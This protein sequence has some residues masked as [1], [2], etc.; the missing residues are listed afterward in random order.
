MSAEPWASQ[1]GEDWRDDPEVFDPD[2]SPDWAERAR[3]AAL[4][5]EEQEE[6]SVPVR[7][8]AGEVWAAG[9]V[10]RLPGPR[11]LGFAAGG[12]LDELAPGRALAGFAEDAEADGL[13]LLDDGELIGLVCAW[14]RLASW[15][16][17]GEATA[18]ITLARRRAAQARE[19][20]NAHLLDHLDDELAAALML[21]GRSAT[22]L[23]SL[24]AGLARL[25]GTLA[26]L[27]AGAVDW[28][29]AVVVVDELAA[30][31]DK[32]ALAAE[33][34]VL[35]GAAGMTTAQL[36]QALRR[37]VLQVDPEA[38]SRRRREARAQ[39]RV[40][41]WDEPSGN[42]ALAGRELPPA[43]VIAADQRVTSLAR[44]LRDRGA[45]GTL[46][47][48]RAAVFTALLAGRPI[49]DLLPDATERPGTEPAAGPAGQGAQAGTGPA[50]SGTPAATGPAP[51][52]EPGTR[53]EPGTASP[54]NGTGRQD[55][56]DPSRGPGPGSGPGLDSEP[57]AEPAAPPVSGSVDLVMPLAT[58]LG[59][60]DTPGEVAGYGPADAD[61]CRDLADRLAR[62]PATRWCITLTDAAGRPVGHACARHGPGCGPGPPGPPGT[63][64]PSHG[65]C[66]AGG[67]LQGWLAGLRMVIFQSGTCA[68]P[69]QSLL[70]QVPRPLR[71]LIQARQRSCSF[72]G[73]RR[74]A[75]RC[76]LDHTIPF[77]QGGKTCECNL[78]PLCR[79]HHQAKQTDGW[80]LD[81]PEPGV[82]AW[83]L[84]HGRSYTVR[85]EPYLV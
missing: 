45:A 4:S 32:D 12:I 53:P 15:A 25:G 41:C 46:D 19:R 75:R 39:A 36:R 47:Q 76:D 77:D 43:E 14:R 85:A 23:L 79:R 44:W 69:R 70:Y 52:T 35:P 22:R 29:R 49:R 9:F 51:G 67:D 20:K 81:Q 26:A 71:H 82:L 63:G 80:R 83:T 55:M 78:T 68:H 54:A 11:G 7:A 28:P 24:A 6:Q 33:A 13:A 2:T 48:L 18:V 50:G 10:H 84:P 65:M 60:S 1:D 66:P 27:S 42:T 16:A 57:G 3:L 37:A 38:A 58:W 17:A 72:P 30:L 8:A 64:P 31:D 74:P 61:S 21:T 59:F 5:P 34:M 73:C 40:E 62:S 56:P